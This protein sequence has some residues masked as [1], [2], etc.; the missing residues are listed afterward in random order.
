MLCV[1]VSDDDDDDVPLPKRRVPF[2]VG[3]KWNEDKLVLM[4][5]LEQL[6]S[7]DHLSKDEIFVAGV[8]RN[9]AFD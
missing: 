4:P 2:A 5:A 6:D 3:L 8:L 1:D 7:L 9:A